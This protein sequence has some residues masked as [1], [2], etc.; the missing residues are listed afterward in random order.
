MN[1]IDT[2]RPTPAPR[3]ILVDDNI[4]NVGG[5][6]FELATLLLGGAQSLGLGC[7]MATHESFDAPGSVPKSWAVVP[8]FGTRRMVRWS[9][10]V[11]GNSHVTR[12]R[13]GN[14]VGGSFV[15]NARTRLSDWMNPPAKRPR[16]MIAQWVDDF[17]GLIAQVKPTASDTILINTGDDFV[18]LALAAALEQI[19]LPPM[20]IDILFH[21]ALYDDETPNRADRLK[22][23]GSQMRSSIVATS[24]HKVHIH[25]TTT[26]LAD[27]LRETDLG[28]PV[29]TISYPTRK[30]AVEKPLDR[31]P[32]KAVL[33]GLPRAEK[34]R[35][36]IAAL[37]TGIEK[38][39]LKTG[40]IQ[41]SMQMPAE[42]WQSMIPATLHRNYEKA[43]SAAESGEVCDGPLEVMTSNLST[44]DYHHWLDTADLGLFLY[45]PKRYVA[46]CSGVLLE[47]LARGVPVIVPDRCWLADQVRLAGGH[48]SIGFIYQDRSEIP[49]LMRQFVKRRAEIHARSIEHARVIARRHSGENVL[50]EMGLAAQ[51]SQRAA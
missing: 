43:A 14:P 27:Q 36:A 34:G 3:L 48:R 13:I 35:D 38:S 7:V 20:R 24:P 11:D 37:I 23:I 47:M 9:M 22:R 8:K 2:A 16:R 18:M 45:E 28:V 50:R 41:L 21:F 15:E 29:N 12:D 5:H 33:A 49:E 30:R 31:L 25:A 17:C 6:F 1:A 19:E 51:Q 26:A 44:S 4:R 40:R 10:G 39:L 32:V 46:R 42:K